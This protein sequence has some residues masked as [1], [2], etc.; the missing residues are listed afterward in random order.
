[1]KQ[2]HSSRI[3]FPSPG[4]PGEGKGGGL[5][6]ISSSPNTKPP[7]Q[8]SP[9]V[10]GEEV[11][12]AYSGIQIS[13]LTLI[14][15]LATAIRIPGLF[16][17]FWFDEIWSWT[18][19]GKLHSIA[20][21]LFAEPARIDNNHPLNTLWLFLL[22]PSAPI[23]LYRMPSLLAGVGSVIV[24]MRIMSRRGFVAAVSAGVLIGF[25]FPFIFY[26]SEARGYSLAVLFGLLA[27]DQLEQNTP[28]TDWLFGTFSALGLLSHFTFLHVLTG[29]F[30]YVVIRR[31]PAAR[32][33]RLFTLPIVTAGFLA[34]V[35]V[36]FMTI[37]GALPTDPKHIITWS[38]SLVF[39]GP[40]HGMTC[41]LAAALALLAFLTALRFDRVCVFFFVAVIAS[42]L[43]TTTRELLADHPQPLMVRYY[44]IC[45][46]FLSLALCPLI[47]RI[48]E[49]SR[50]D[51]AGVVVCAV[52]F[53]AG[54]LIH[55]TRFLSLGRGQVVAMLRHIDES[56]STDICSDSIE[57]T[58]TYV[59]FYEP[60]LHESFRLDSEPAEWL[61]FNRESMYADRSTAFHGV[62]YDLDSVY[63]TCSLSGWP[64]WLYH[65]R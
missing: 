26:S 3:S 61:I 30:V 53:L 39:N 42:P 57:R 23:W 36:R 62:Q 37:G 63:P 12:G 52:L 1:M 65:R 47:Q 18:I 24:A 17:D 15:V 19:A 41:V 33:V 64:L 5:G 11:R 2:R 48:W 55:E 13:C 8:S 28:R 59:A 51:R 7:P 43:L 46:A 32:L 16:T 50:F 4:T 38:L 20:D 6:A 56:G 40:D 10:P 22:G 45:L 21:I 29:A 31:T 34:R 54:A 9:R 58:K 35:F 25:G 44:L 60:R 14:V 27:F 49:R